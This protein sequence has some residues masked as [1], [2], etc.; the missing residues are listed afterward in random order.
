MICNMR[1]EWL[2]Y[3]D[4]SMEY[5]GLRAGWSEVRVPAEVGNFSLHHCVQT[6]SGPHPASYRMGTRDFFLGGK[7]A[8]TWSWPLPPS[9]AEIKMRGVV[10]QLSNTLS[11]RIAQLKHR[12]N[13]IFTLP[14]L[15]WSAKNYLLIFELLHE[16]LRNWILFKR[17]FS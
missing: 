14:Y 7:A 2:L 12:N 10:P 16:R 6:G 8:R 11:W 1:C 5:A 9:S 17:I 3:R 4:S 13:F 15:Y